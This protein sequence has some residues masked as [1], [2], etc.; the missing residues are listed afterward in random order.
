[1]SWSFE[2]DCPVYAP[3]HIDPEIDFES[4]ED[5]LH[6]KLQARGELYVLKSKCAPI[7]AEIRKS[8]DAIEKLAEQQATFLKKLSS[9]PTS[10]EEELARINIPIFTGSY[11]DCPS[12]KDLFVSTVGYRAA[13]S[14]TQ[15]STHST[16][17]CYKFG[18]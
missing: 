10:G 8:G 16:H 1:M 18:I 12:F 17:T 14:N 11:K 13:L 6:Y 5:K 9:I 2:P 4:Y 15:D 3:M 7:T